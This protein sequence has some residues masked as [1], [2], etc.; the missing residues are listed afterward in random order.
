MK[1]TKPFIALL[2]G[3][4][5]LF[6]IV[7]GQDFSGTNLSSSEPFYKVAPYEFEQSEFYFASFKT[8]PQVI[9]ALVP[10]PL[11]PFGDEVQLYFAKHHLTSPFHLD[12]N[13]VYFLI[14]VSLGTQF[15]GYMPV[16]YLDDVA[17]IIPGR[18]I[19]GF[20]KVGAIIEFKED[21][22]MVTIE[23]IQTD[24]LIIKADFVL[25]PSV[26]PPAKAMDAGSINLKYIPSALENTPPEVKQLTFVKMEDRGT[27]EL[28]P[29]EVSLSFYSSKFNPLNAIPI[30]EI[31]KGT[32][33]KNSFSLTDTQ[34]I[35]D[36]LKEEE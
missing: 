20:N 29:A 6:E 10:E 12:Y 17:G 1:I 14:I 23:V 30:L 28:R 18:E 36:Y 21:K 15:A 11:I 3:A 31:T 2:I 13:E 25:G 32:Y 4:I 26:P 19:A 9:K 24:T 27:T 34:I 7:K 33:Y 35:Y 5:S 22:N 16:L 8:D